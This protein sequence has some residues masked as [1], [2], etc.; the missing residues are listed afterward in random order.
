MSKSE[1]EEFFQQRQQLIISAAKVCFSQSGFHGASMADISRESGL[2]AGQ[3]YRYFESKELIVSETIKS[4]AANWRLFLQNNLP[5]QS[6]TADIINT[7]SGFWQDWPYQDRCLLLEMYSEAS[8]NQAVRAVLAQEE[9]LLIAELETS[10]CQQSPGVSD[11]QCNE[12]IQF[13][14][15]LVDGVACR[16]FGDNTLD[17]REK[18]RINGILSHHLFG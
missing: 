17:H 11:Q 5:R 8:R 16:A 12:R 4:I 6:S 3:I 13:L 1:N 15:M 2:G 10:L 14:L 7:E 9:Q 18:G